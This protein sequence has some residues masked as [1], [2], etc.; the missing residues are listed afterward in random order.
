MTERN[1]WAGWVSLGDR[2][3]E[4]CELMGGGCRGP[5]RPAGLRAWSLP[6]AGWGLWKGA[7]PE[8]SGSGHSLPRTQEQP[9]GVQGCAQHDTPAGPS[10]QKCPPSRA[11]SQGLWG[12][13]VPALP[14][15]PPDL[16]L[17]PFAVLAPSGACPRCSTLARS[18]WPPASVATGASR[19][20][21]ADGIRQGQGAQAAAP[22]GPSLALL[23]PLASLQARV[24]A[25]VLSCKDLLDWVP[26]P[27]PAR[28][29]RT[30]T[31]LDMGLSGFDPLQH[32]PLLQGSP[33]LQGRWWQGPC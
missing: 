10:S 3:S 4:L 20:S 26:G 25:L 21:L 13:P 1:L 17:E 27:P 22:P 2:R 24:L 31:C 12:K 30:A 5:W 19:G 15:P 7:W 18:D 8:S 16:S 11:P 14:P 9:G 29:L 6:V 33:A 28:P 32:R 23:A